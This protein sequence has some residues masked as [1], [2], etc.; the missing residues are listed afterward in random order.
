MYNDLTLEELVAY[1]SLQKEPFQF[2]GQWIYPEDA[3]IT[4]SYTEEINERLHKKQISDC[5]TAIH[6]EMSCSIEEDKA[7]KEMLKQKERNKKVNRSKGLYKKKLIFLSKCHWSICYY[8]EKYDY[9]TRY[10]RPKMSKQIKKVCNRTVR[11]YKHGLS[12]GGN[13]KKIT[14]FWHELY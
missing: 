14:E 13:Y 2:G 5:H 9:M 3:N 7:L 11:Y 12:K 8:N 10:Y 4:E 1:K 6:K